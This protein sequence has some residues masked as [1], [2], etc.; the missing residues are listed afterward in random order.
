MLGS[1]GE[2]NNR[3]RTGRGR[4]QPL[5]AKLDRALPAG[6]APSGATAPAT[7]TTRCSVKMLCAAH[8]LEHGAARRLADRACSSS[9]SP[10]RR[11]EYHVAATFPS[12]CGKTNFAMPC[13]AQGPWTVGRSHHRR[14]H[15]LDQAQQGT[16]ASPSTRRPA[17]SASRRAP[18]KSSTPATLVTTRDVI[19]TNVALT[20]DGTHGGRGDGTPAKRPR[21]RST[22]RA[23]DWTDRKRQGLAPRQHIQCPLHRCA[24]NNP[25]LDAP[26]TTRPA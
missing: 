15:C 25:A 5:A 4:L 23:K 14:R 26:G 20:D 6:R 21:T 13:P 24:T 16:V 12:A 11:Q 19:F 2:F 8:R 17:T 18:T 9:R 7:A 10:I 22:G 1:D 3:R